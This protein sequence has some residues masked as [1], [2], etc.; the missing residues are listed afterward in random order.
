M[1]MISMM[2]VVASF[3][4]TASPLERLAENLLR[5]ILTTPGLV[6]QGGKIGILLP[7]P[8]GPGGKLPAMAIGM[9]DPVR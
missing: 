4:R 1:V 2:V 8:V 3:Q 7:Q 5:F 9:F 6:Q